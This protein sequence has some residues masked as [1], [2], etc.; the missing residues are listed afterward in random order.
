MSRTLN[1]SARALMIASMAHFL[2]C[3]TVSAPPSAHRLCA[4]T[5]TTSLRLAGFPGGSGVKANFILLA[6]PGR[7]VAGSNSGA[8]QQSSIPTKRFEGPSTLNCWDSGKG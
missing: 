1:M 5:S 8:T 6:H 7:P 2:P 4:T 3:S